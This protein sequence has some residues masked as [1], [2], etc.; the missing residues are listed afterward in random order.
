M[1]VLAD[2]VGI[3][4]PE[5]AYGLNVPLNHPPAGFTGNESDRFRLGN[6]ESAEEGLT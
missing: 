5:T 1:A 2:E 4:S 6:L 3:H